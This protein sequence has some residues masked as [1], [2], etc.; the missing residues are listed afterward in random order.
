MRANGKGT[1]PKFV[2]GVAKGRRKRPSFVK[3][4]V[5]AEATLPDADHTPTLVQLGPR[6]MVLLA[7]AMWWLIY[8]P[9]EMAQTFSSAWAR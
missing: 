7:V 1:P 5:E 2:N 3:V 9:L 8:P 6:M 4:A